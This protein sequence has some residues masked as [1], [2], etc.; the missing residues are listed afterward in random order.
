[1]A[2]P[3]SSRLRVPSL[4]LKIVFAPSR[5]RVWSVKVS[6][7]RDSTP[8]RTAVPSRTSSLTAP[9]GAR[10]AQGTSLTSLITWLTRASFELGR[11]QVSEPY[12]EEKERECG[13]LLEKSSR[14]ERRPSRIKGCWPNESLFFIMRSVLVRDRAWSEGQ[15]GARKGMA[16]AKPFCLFG[17]AKSSLDSRSE[18]WKERL[19]GHR[20]YQPPGGRPSEGALERVCGGLAPE[21]PKVPV[22]FPLPPKP[23]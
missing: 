17:G 21:P 6:S 9:A 7:A 3:P 1:M 2:P 23:V 11:V 8:V 4:K 10:L 22:V 16:V 15:T 5:A 18:R 14:K 20:R 12:E 19:R 13:K